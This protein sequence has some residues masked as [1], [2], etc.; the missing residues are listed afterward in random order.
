MRP[1][2]YGVV[3]ARLE[4]QIGATASVPMFLEE[5][6]PPSSSGLGRRP[7]TAVTGIRTPL[8]VPV[9]SCGAVW[10]A[11]RPVKAEAAGS[12]PVRTASAS[13]FGRL[14]HGRVAQSAE[15]TPEKRGVTGSTPVPATIAQARHETAPN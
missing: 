12:N 13:G 6:E 4:L 14:L 8:G 9:W 7:F 15:H 5:R 10:S 1:G 2:I 11:R 3:Q